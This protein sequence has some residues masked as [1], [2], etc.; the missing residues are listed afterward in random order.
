MECILDCVITKSTYIVSGI[1]SPNG[2]CE[3][4][5]IKLM[6]SDDNDTAPLRARI[7]VSLQN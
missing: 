5:Y 4:R 1:P 2:W 3:M 7:M 6:V